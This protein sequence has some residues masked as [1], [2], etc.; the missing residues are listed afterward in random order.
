VQAIIFS[1]DRPLQLDTTLRSF[2]LHCLDFNQVSVRIIVKASNELYRHAYQL[3]EKEYLLYTN[4]SLISETDFRQ[5]VLDLLEFDEFVLW[6]VDDNI[7]VRDFYIGNCQQLLETNQDSLGYSLRL[8][9]NTTYCYPLD[10]QQVVPD[11]SKITE[12]N[13]KYNWTTAELDFAYPLE[14][15]SSVFRTRDMKPF[16]ESLKFIN[17]NSLEAEMAGNSSPFKGSYP[18]HLC[19]EL[20]LT[21]CNPINKVQATFEKNRAG[22]ISP[23]SLLVEYLRGSRVD[24][25]LYSGFTPNACH[26]EVAFTFIDNEYVCPKVSVIIPCYN[27]AHFLAE[28]VESVAAQTFKDWECLIVNDGSPDNTS[29]VAKRLIERYPDK[30]IKL[31]EKPNGGLADARNFGIMQAMGA[32]ILPLDSDDIIHPEMLC[33]TVKLLDSHPHIAIVYTDRINFGAEQKHVVLKEYHFESLKY[34]NLL[35]YCSLYRREVWEQVGGYNTNMISGYED[36]DFWI[37]AGELK[38]IAQHL[39]EALLFYRVKVESMFTKSLEHDAELKANI[40]MNHPRIY[41]EHDRM[42]AKKVLDIPSSTDQSSSPPKLLGVNNKSNPCNPDHIRQGYSTKI[43]NSAHFLLNDKCNARCV[44]CGGNYYNSLS[45]R[46]ITLEKFKIIAKNI[47]LEHYRQAVLAGAGDPLLSPDFVPI[48]KYLHAMYPTLN[49]AVTSNGIR[50]NRE[51]SE[52]M[53]ACGVTLLNISL[54]A[55]T[56]ETYQRLMQVDAFDRI[57]R[58]IQEFSALCIE[59]CKNPQLQISIPIMRCNVEELFLL[60][61]LAHDVGAGSV[62]VFYCRFYPRE[63]RND[64]DGGFLTDKESLFFHQELSDKIVRES[65][66]LAEKLGIQLH[67]E[68]LFSQGFVPKCCSWTENELMIGFDGEVFPCGGGELHFRKKLERGEYDFG[69]ALQQT[70]E[71]F[72]NN[73]SYR[74]IRVSSKRDGLCVI[75]ECRECSNMTSHME[76][77]GHILEW[78]DFSI[79]N[80]SDARDETSSPPPLV[81]I[82]VPTHDRPDMLKNAI[83]SIFYQA[84]QNFEIIVVNDAGE[85]VE[86]VI[87]AFNSPKINYIQHETNKGLAAARNTGIRAA[88]GKYIAYLDDDDIFYPEHLETLVNLLE[89][90]EYQVAYTDA[91]RVTQIKEGAAYAAVN[92]EYLY[93]EEFDYD[94]ILSENFIP[95]LCIMHEKSCI[96]SAGLFDETLNRHEDWDLWIRMSREYSFA[97][98]KKVTCAYSMRP[99]GSGMVSGSVPA[100]LRTFDAICGKYFYL[101]AD[102]PDILNA[103][104]LLRYSMLEDT[105]NF[106]GR[107]LDTIPEAAHLPAP[108]EYILSLLYNTGATE[109]EIRSAFY[110][111]AGLRAVNEPC[112]AI[113]LLQEALAANPENIVARQKIAEL[114]I[115]SGKHGKA[116]SHLEMLYETN[117][118]AAPSLITTLVNYFLERDTSKARLYLERLFEISPHNEQARQRLEL[119][120]K[121]EHPPNLTSVKKPI[122]IAVFSYDSKEHACGHYRI[123]APLKKLAGELELSWGVE[124][125]EK[126]FHI[127]S[128]VAEAADII[129]VQRSFPRAETADFLYYLCSLCKP[130]IFE[131]DDLLTQLPPTNLNCGWGMDCTP[132]IYE[133]IRKCSAVTV[134]TEELKKHFTAYSDAIYILPNLLDSD[135]W[136]KTSPPSSGPVVIGY[137]GTITHDT[138][139][140]LLE[141]VLDR[142]ASSYGTS[143]EAYARNLQEIPI[144]IMLAPLEDNPF[145]RCKSNIKWLE[146]SSCGIA[147]IYSDLPPYNNCIEH[148]TTGFLAGS[149]TQ[150]WFDAIDLLIKNPELRRTI[151]MNARQKI[152]TEHTVKMWAQRWFQV[153][154]EIIS[155]HATRNATSIGDLSEPFKVDAQ[156]GWKH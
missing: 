13:Y 22:N 27:Q 141:D 63:I 34:A 84:L 102:R 108:T 124:I 57:C 116:I 39:P 136:C 36:W 153:Y 103:Q 16:L 5:Q 94:R 105:Y 19:S 150:Q 75:P 48:L 144:D 130:I 66:K 89:S 28:C 115:N 59:R 77:R 12:T 127:I 104:K 138:D 64:K 135:L 18:Y 133:F 26:Q 96:Y 21:F 99:D 54:N 56:K 97:H 126:A 67:H 155:L 82:I 73:D 134:T 14:V 37:G 4:I 55:A 33:R 47:H 132:Y 148:C 91:C 87:I 106:L 140:A 142:I 86:H 83:Q 98:I 100:F 49:I 120:R 95:V 114:L 9:A 68:P 123:Q 61:K 35:N 11:F 31:L 129:V 6:L 81:S 53:L 8:G 76:Q 46:R 52:A 101:T 156:G 151:A 147:G 112:R 113:P 40:I 107:K 69:N 125:R 25:S 137:A 30:R 3:I 93:S 79:S 85:D 128:G 7:F 15:S 92:V 38:F 62:N 58:Q 45:G 74:A 71:A 10:K 42:W 1:K 44:F 88:R 131:I 149:D 32:Y 110:L 23:C 41:G 24:V 117:P 90:S 20:S 78:A 17:P 80:G 72:W 65:E 51:L 109:S 122:N 121:D 154:Q 139:L 60:I 29:E 143:F 2:M 146:Y 111:R 119:L 152:I 145:N 50:L 118:F 70:I 43:P